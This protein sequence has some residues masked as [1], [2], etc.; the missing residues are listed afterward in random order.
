MP[1]FD[2]AFI[3]QT[4]KRLE[5]LTPESKP[6]WGKMTCPQMMGHLN[7]TIIY[8]L[9]NLPAIPGSPSWAYRNIIGPLILNGIMKL[10]KNLTPPRPEGT[11]APPPPPPGNAQM[12]LNAMEM[13]LKGLEAGTIK[14]APHPGFGD[15]GAEGW[16][17]MHVVHTDHHLR[18]FGA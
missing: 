12:L 10:P 7:M 5:Q 4:A 13:Y 2:R 16:G 8:S 6:L 14:A 3:D 18:Q 9:G 11:P 17:K 1:K 15:I